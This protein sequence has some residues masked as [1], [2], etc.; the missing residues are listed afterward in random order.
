MEG[1]QSIFV[2]S[3]L[4]MGDGGPR[5]SFAVGDR[6]RQ[7]ALFL[8]YVA[9]QQGELM[10]LGDLF[11][12][13]QMNLS[14]IILRHRPLLDRLAGMQATY[15]LGNHDGD[16]EHFVGTDLLSCP[17]FQRMRGPI[18]R[19]TFVEDDLEEPAKLDLRCNCEPRR[20]R[21]RRRRVG[22]APESARVG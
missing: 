11:E 1:S 3:D 20:R 8:D 6:E 17:F 12:F 10:V 2:I 18:E 7:L 9:N 5:D 21:G 15:V 19:A 16:L 13:W 14:A 22:A 4:H